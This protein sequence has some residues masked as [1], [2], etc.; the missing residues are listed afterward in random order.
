[1]QAAS[2]GTALFANWAARFPA[3]AERLNVRAA[4]LLGF[5]HS[6]RETVAASDRMPQSSAFVI[7]TWINML[8]QVSKCMRWGTTHTHIYIDMFIYTRTLYIYIYIYIYIYV[9]IYICIY[10]Y[11]CMYVYV[12]GFRHPNLD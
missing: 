9:Y 12:V 4:M 7:R 11:I 6:V 3:D 1:M 2:F 8:K 10:I 5:G